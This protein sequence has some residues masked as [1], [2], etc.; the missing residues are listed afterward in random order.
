MALVGDSVYCVSLL[1]G[2]G[3]ALAI[4]GAYVLAGELAQANGALGLGLAVYERRLRPYIET[5]QAGAARLAGALAPR[6]RFGLWFRN[7]VVRSLRIPSVAKRA[8]G[9]EIIDRLDLPA[10]PL[11]AEAH[12][13]GAY[14]AA[15]ASQG[16]NAEP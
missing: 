3:S 15:A 13:C 4:V 12:R 11:A 10:Y 14:V 5:K 7:T 16:R 8:V 2:Q 9:R 6:T 1:A